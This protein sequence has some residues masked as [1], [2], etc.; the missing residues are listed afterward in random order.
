MSP[1]KFKYEK[2]NQ[3]KDEGNNKSIYTQLQK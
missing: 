2:S 1:S 3:S